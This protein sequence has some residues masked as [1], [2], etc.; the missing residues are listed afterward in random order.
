M[1]ERTIVENDTEDK[2]S[3]S[4][5]EWIIQRDARFIRHMEQLS[6]Q[7]GDRVLLGSTEFDDLMRLAKAG[8]ISA[9]NEV[10]TAQYQGE[11]EKSQELIEEAGALLGSIATNE[12][13][14]ILRI[15]AIKDF[16]KKLE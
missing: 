6:P 12:E 2:V 3:N 7:S 4:H 15:G 13:A 10:T 11:I 8:I 1:R 14:T 9:E 5:I 16:L